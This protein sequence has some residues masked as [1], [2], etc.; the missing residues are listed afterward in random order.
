MELTTIEHK[1]AVDLNLDWSVLESQIEEIIRDLD[2]DPTTDMSYETEEDL[3]LAEF[4]IEEEH[5]EALDSNL[6]Y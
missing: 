4:N 1:T 6:L 2:I 3:S 5:Q